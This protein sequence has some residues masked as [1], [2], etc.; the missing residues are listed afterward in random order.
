MGDSMKQ[1]NPI[2]IL[3]L[4]VGLWLFGVGLRMLTNYLWDSSMVYPTPTPA[5]FDWWFDWLPMV[6]LGIFMLWLGF[7]T[8]LY[9][10]N[11]VY[12]IAE[13]PSQETQNMSPGCSLNL[14]PFVATVLMVAITIILAIILYMIV[15]GVNW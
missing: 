12:D 4:L 7:K 2:K 1:I 13:S 11:P 8:S 3:Y 5:M 15:Y 10:T 14:S 6:P 9:A